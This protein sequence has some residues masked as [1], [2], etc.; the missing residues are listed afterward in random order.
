MDITKTLFIEPYDGGSHRAFR[1]GLSNHSRHH[2]ESLTLPPRFWKWRMRGAAVWFAD[3]IN[4]M[5]DRSWDLLF[6]TGYLNLADLRGLLAPPLDRVPVLL[7]LHENQLTYPLSP[8][9]EFDFHFGFTNIVSA[10]AADRVVFNSEYHRDLFMEFLPAYLGKMPE[11][12]P[13]GV[14]ERLL[15]RSGV[16]GVGLDR[17]RLPEDHFPQYRGG[18]CD[19]QTGPS[20]PRGRRPLLLWNHRWEFDK[21]PDQFVQAMFTLLDEGLDF[22]VA[23]LGESRGHDEVF[24]P[25]RDRLK[26]RCVA[27]G[28]QPDRRDYD[29]LLDRSDIVVSCA[30]QEYFGISVAEAIHAGCYPVLPRSQVYPSMY[31]TRCRG[32]HFYQTQEE[33]VSLLQDLINGKECGHVCSLDCDVDQY[34]WERLALEFDG[35]IAETVACGRRGTAGGRAGEGIDD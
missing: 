2:F 32:R 5:S 35:L 4:E 26:E 14:K 20:W 21:R 16:V 12:V 15:E 6:V 19:P 10:L 24:G 11:G 3:L 23:L 29:R 17:P 33:L 8:Q 25:L 30:E 13:R 28:F 7:Y 9:E 1:K 31:G 18:P 22:E 27:F 34:C